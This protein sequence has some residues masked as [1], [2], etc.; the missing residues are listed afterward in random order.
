MTTT[1]A[2]PDLL[3]MTT[4]ELDDLF[5][6]AEPGP[7]PEGSAE[8]TAIIA[9]GTPF[10]H[11]IASLINHVAWQGKVFNPATG[12]LLNRVLPTGWNA[13]AAKVYSGE[14]WF[15]HK[16]CVVLDYSHTSLIAHWIR[17]EIRRIG[18]GLYLGK[19][20]WDKTPIFH[21]SLKF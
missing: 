8:G 6:R 13:V 15:D 14:S 18:P 17:D 3:S 7:I 10:S 16:P 4:A 11:E 2:T 1:A 9:A 20:Y 19:V 5:G 21:F 12:E